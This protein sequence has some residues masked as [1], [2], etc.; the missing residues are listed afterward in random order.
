MNEPVSVMTVF[1]TA[2]SD[3]WSICTTT[4]TNLTG[5]AVWMIPLAIP[6]AGA[7][8]AFTKRL[9][10]VGGGKRRGG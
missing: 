1:T 2:I 9:V 3:F 7:A 5:N 10:K 8:L 4:W 6:V